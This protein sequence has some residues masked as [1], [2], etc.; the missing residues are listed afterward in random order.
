MLK[1][2]I[3]NAYYNNKL[4]PLTV[5]GCG[6]I[7]CTL[8]ADKIPYL[9]PIFVKVDNRFLSPAP[10]I[11]SMGLTSLTM[12]FTQLCFIFALS[13]GEIFAESSFGKNACKPFD[14]V[15]FSS[16]HICRF[17]GLVPKRIKR[18]FSFELFNLYLYV[19][20]LKL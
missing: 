18:H 8:A 13:I 19:P 7:S 16:K 15:T 20:N 12:N 1:I 5:V 3:H 2:N 4:F 9:W 14:T 11:E 10:D 17:N 6:K